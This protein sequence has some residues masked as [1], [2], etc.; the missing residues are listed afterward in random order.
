MRRMIVAIVA[1]VGIFSTL[2]KSVQ[3]VDTTYVISTSTPSNFSTI[4]AGTTFDISGKVDWPW[5]KQNID[6]ISIYLDDFSGQPLTLIQSQC[7][8]TSSGSSCNFNTPY[9]YLPSP[10][11]YLIWIKAKRNGVVINEAALVIYAY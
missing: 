7:L 10:G 6:Q 3:A 1:S 9:G 2:E 4:S 5:Y 8:T 11:S